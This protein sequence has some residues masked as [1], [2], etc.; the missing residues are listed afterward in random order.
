[1]YVQRKEKVT[2]LLLLHLLF[3]SIVLTIPDHSGFESRGIRTG[4]GSERFVSYEKYGNA[5]VWRGS[6]LSI[7]HTCSVPTMLD[8]RRFP[9]DSH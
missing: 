1:M 6:A 3:S 4:E 9:E 2:A 8:R 7:R 5:R